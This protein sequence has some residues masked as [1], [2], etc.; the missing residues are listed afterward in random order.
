M[1]LNMLRLVAQLPQLWGLQEALREGASSNWSSANGPA[2][3]KR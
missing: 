3:N 2:R 1:L